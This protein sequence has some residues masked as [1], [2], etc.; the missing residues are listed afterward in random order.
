MN[1]LAQP[2][3]RIGATRVLLGTRE[4]EYFAG[5]DYLGLSWEPKLLAAVANAVLGE[6]LGVGASRRT[7]GNHPL[8][9]ELERALQRY[10]GVR[11]AL[12]TGTGYTANWVAAEAMAGRFSHVLIDE[13]SHMSLQQAA[14]VMG[15]KIQRFRHRDPE[16]LE[17]VQRRL[18][19]GSGIVL[20][21]DGVFARDGS[22]APL[23]EY[24][25]R[26]RPSAWLW[27]D[28]CHGVGVLGRRG[29]GS[30]EFE[31]VL[32][33]RLIQT[34]TLSKAFGVQGGV[35]LGDSDVI[36]AAM[37]RSS[38]FAGST[39]LALPL[40][41]GALFSVTQLASDPLRRERLM[42]H[43][44]Q[45]KARL[46]SSGLLDVATPGPMFFVDASPRLA[47]RMK[48]H[49]LNQGILPPWIHYPGGPASGY[50]RFALC[51]EHTPQSVETLLEV[52]EAV[53]KPK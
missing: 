42:S 24:R 31:G 33:E 12:L 28:D 29:R 50:F 26:L 8:Y 40:A 11:A 48:R 41:A 46:V 51:S 53:G 10:F 2:M 49:L 18:P 39:P 4:L 36:E 23:R 32:A 38:C 6:G 52:L 3:R 21:T 13:R 44:K 27:V 37:E 14:W 16:D 25:K 15:A 5:C 9:G 17:R 45:V 34:L 30:V 1:P 7:T 22:V 19:A 20:M 43:T 47:G 35:I